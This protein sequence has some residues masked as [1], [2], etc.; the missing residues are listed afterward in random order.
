MVQQ[1]APSFLSITTQT[2]SPIR[3]CTPRNLLLR[4]TCRPKQML[5]RAA[6]NRV[7]HFRSSTSSPAFAGLFSVDHSPIPSLPRFIRPTTGLLACS[8]ATKRK[9]PPTN[10][11]SKGS[12][13]AKRARPEVPEYHLTPSV[14]NEDGE[15]QWPAPKA[16]I[17]RA[18]EIIVERYVHVV[19]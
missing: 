16:Q 9:I 15:I 6:A 13:P 3:S 8:M 4:E 18:R 19:W 10:A 7:F 17:A 11:T 12:S 2:T 14:K 1:S 5:W